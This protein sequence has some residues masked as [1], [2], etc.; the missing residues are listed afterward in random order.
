MLKVE[1]LKR[2]VSRQNQKKVL[3]KRNGLKSQKVG[4]CWPIKSEEEVR[5][6]AL[7]GT[8]QCKGGRRIRKNH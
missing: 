5:A 1:R 4:D 3:V 7:S 6:H 8:Q 2:A